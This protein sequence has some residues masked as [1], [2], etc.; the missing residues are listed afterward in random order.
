MSEERRGFLFCPG[1]PV[2]DKKFH[3]FFLS[4]ADK[5]KLSAVFNPE[6]KC[7]N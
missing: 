2:E 6:W 4:A 3:K 7:P 5:K 1:A